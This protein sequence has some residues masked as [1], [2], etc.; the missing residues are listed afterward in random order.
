[1]GILTS[2]YT[3]Y[4]TTGVREDL[5]DIISNITPVETWFQST[6]GSTRATQRYHEWL[7]DSLATAAANAQIEGNQ[8]SAT[9]ITAP[10][11]TGNYCQILGKYFAITETEEISNKAGRDSEVAYQKANKLKELANDIEYAMIVN[12]SSVTGATGTARQLKG[13]AGWITSNTITGTGTENQPL[14]QTLLDDGLQACWKAG[15]KPSNCIMG[16]FQKRKIDAFTTNTRNVNADEK[17]LVSTVSVY[18]GSHGTVTLRLHHIMEDQLSSKIFILGDMGLWKKAW[19]RPLK[20][21][22][23]PY[24]GFAEFW[25]CEAELTLEARNEAG[26]AVIAELTTS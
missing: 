6:I 7:K 18:E 15:G 25:G 26:A 24:T 11:R 23:L 14:T 19:L 9:A 12:S 2:T 1:M 17:K 22:A 4:D 20:W 16:S 10:T 5:I 3:T 21:K 13:L 8:V